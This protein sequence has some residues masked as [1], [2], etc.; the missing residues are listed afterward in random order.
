MLIFFMYTMQ[1]TDEARRAAK[2]EIWGNWV[3]FKPLET[4]N[5]KFA[6]FITTDGVGASVMME[7]PKQEETAAPADIDLEGK[8]VVGVD[9][10]ITDFFS[11]VDEN[12]EKLKCSTGEYYHHAGFNHS[13]AWR[14]RKLHEAPMQFEAWQ[15]AIPSSHASSVAAVQHHVAYVTE[16]LSEAL[17]HHGTQQQR[18]LRWNCH[19]KKQRYMHVMAKRLVGSRPKEEVIIGWGG[20]STGHGSCISR[21]GRGPT[22]ELLHLLRRQYARVKIID[23]YKTSQVSRVP[24]RVLLHVKGWTSFWTLV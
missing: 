9:P 16:R 11:A 21:R 8:R 19:I 12:D 3:D 5:H 1:A 4:A 10:G 7:R 15:S 23:E 18:R 6:C 22:K 13:R 14:E 24:P 20:A 17:G 2:L